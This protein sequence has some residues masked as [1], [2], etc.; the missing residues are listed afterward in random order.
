[1]HFRR[2]VGLV[3]ALSLSLFAGFSGAC[4]SKTH[5]DINIGTNLGMD[6]V[7]EVHDAS[8]D[9]DGA[10]GSTGSGGAAGSGGA[11]G[12]GGAAGAGG[13]GGTAAADDAAGDAADDGAA[14]LDNG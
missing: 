4:S 8:A 14:T 6:F 13:S 5:T 11:T 10:G 2:S 7:P 9:S 3:A 1:M 12:S